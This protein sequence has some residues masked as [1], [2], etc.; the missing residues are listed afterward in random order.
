MPNPPAL[1]CTPPTCAPG[2]Q[3]VESS[4]ASVQTLLPLSLAPSFVALGTLLN[5][6]CLTF[7][8]CRMHII[9]ILPPR[10]V[11]GFNDL[12]KH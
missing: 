11:R 3:F 12:I 10:I 5:L 6:A 7:L 8:I 2:T 9:T 4:G 1:P